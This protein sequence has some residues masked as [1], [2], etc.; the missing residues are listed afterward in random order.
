[1]FQAAYSIGGL[2][3][4]GRLKYGDQGL[5]PATGPG[6]VKALALKYRY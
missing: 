3:P 5:A 2:T 6:L 1:M 4:V